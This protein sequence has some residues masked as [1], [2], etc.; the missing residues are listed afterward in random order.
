[1]RSQV[2]A[3][4]VRGED[5]ASRIVCCAW[6]WGESVANHAIATIGSGDP[7]LCGWWD[8]V[9][10]APTDTADGAG[11]R[12]TQHAVSEPKSCLFS[13]GQGE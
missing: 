6:T 8:V 5:V 9:R 1:V 2:R 7:E 11:G 4:S 13:P 12:F 10:V 3:A